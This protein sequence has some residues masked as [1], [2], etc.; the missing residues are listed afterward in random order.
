[1]KLMYWG[2][3]LGP[4][5]LQMG[6][7]ALDS[8]E[9]SA[10]K[11]SG[12]IVVFKRELTNDHI[13]RHIDWVN[14]MH[15][16]N[17]DGRDD[18]D[19]SQGIKHTYR[20]DAIGFHGYSGRFSDEVLQQIKQHEH[21]DFVEEDRI[22]TLEPGKRDQGQGENP[23]VDAGNRNK[24]NGVGILRQGQGYNSFLE[25]GRIFDAIVWRDNAKRDQEDGSAANETFQAEKTMFEFTPPSTGPGDFANIDMKEYFTVPET[26]EI[27]ERVAAEIKELKEE[28]KKQAEGKAKMIETNE[29]QTR[30]ENARCP[31]ILRKEYKLTEDYNAEASLSFWGVKADLSVDAKKQLE[32][33]NKH[34]NVEVSLFYQGELG[35]FMER[36]EGAPKDISAGSVEAVLGQVKSWADKFEKHACNQDYAY[37]PLL[38]EYTVLPAFNQ[39]DDSPQIPDYTIAHIWALEILRLM[40]KIEEQKKVLSSG[41]VLDDAQKIEMTAAAIDMM[42]K[43]KKWVY[44]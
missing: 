30:A 36:D 42:E 27:E 39:L 17:L 23:P 1:M 35:I 21:V 26:S 24:K 19:Q 5:M 28:M 7:A 44:S 18:T 16:G 6:A 41:A 13:D 22:I 33:V 12:H 15:K 40:V 4:T 8:S 38:N 32:E 2:L 14:Q 31:G 9:N 29:I 43:C 10:T 3:A 25:K 11:P 34:I 37:G 20:S